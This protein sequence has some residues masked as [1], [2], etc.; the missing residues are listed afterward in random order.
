MVGGTTSEERIME[1][2]RLKKWMIGSSPNPKYFFTC[3][4]P[5]RSTY[6]YKRTNNDVSDTTVSEWLGGLPRPKTAIVSLLGRKPDR[7]NQ[8]EFSF[9]SFCGGWDTP[10]ESRDKP[11]FRDWLRQRHGE[12]QILVREYPTNDLQEITAEQLVAIS[13]TIRELISEGH[14]VVV[15]DSGGVGRV[16]Q[17]CTFMNATEIR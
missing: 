3:A 14:A 7:G 10:S 6:S 12:L 2:H 13:D 15:V 8:S 4:R 11:T 5:G 1:P 17:V 9:Y 16:G